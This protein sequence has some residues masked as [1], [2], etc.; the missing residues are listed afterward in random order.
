M[1]YAKY[2]EN[3]KNMARFN[4]PPLADYVFKMMLLEAIRCHNDGDY[5]SFAWIEKTMVMMAT[6]WEELNRRGKK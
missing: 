5:V 4:N 1:Y 6:R 2:K 3:I